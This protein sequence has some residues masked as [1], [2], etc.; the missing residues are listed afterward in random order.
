MAPRPSL[1][2]LLT[3]IQ[4]NNFSF[5]SQMIFLC[6]LY[7]ATDDCSITKKMAKTRKCSNCIYK[8]INKLAH[9][10]YY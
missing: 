4:N 3:L 9:L 5:F 8:V 6:L 1:S 2:T 10:V 7:I